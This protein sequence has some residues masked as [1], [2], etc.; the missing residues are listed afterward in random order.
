MKETVTLPNCI[1]WNSP[2]LDIVLIVEGA[3]SVNNK[4]LILME[5]VNIKKKLKQ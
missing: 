5:K 3:K 1:Q 4:T 2:F